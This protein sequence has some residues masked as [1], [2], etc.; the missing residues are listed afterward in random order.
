MLKNIF[1]IALFCCAALALQAQTTS[2]K[3][4]N[5]NLEIKIDAKTIDS[6]FAVLEKSLPALQ[7]KALEAT[8]ELQKDLP[9]MKQE[10][11]NEL[12][13]ANFELQQAIV[14]LD[15]TLKEWLEKFPVS[16]EK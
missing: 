4:A 5:E 6:C 2:P 16:I 10:L 3:N 1:L 14:E 15:K 8:Q 11:K 7:H 13:V 12:Q 9:A